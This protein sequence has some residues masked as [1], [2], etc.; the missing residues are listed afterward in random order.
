MQLSFWIRIP[1][2]VGVNAD[3]DNITRTAKFLSSLQWNNPVVNLLPYHD[4]G[5]NKHEKL[6]TIYNPYN[7]SFSTPNDNQILHIRSIFYEHGI[8]TTIGG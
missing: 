4:N 2:I 6:G 1:R 3:D 8:T 5:K 7:Y